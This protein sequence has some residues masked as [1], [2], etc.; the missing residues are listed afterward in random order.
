MFSKELEDLINY[1]LSDGEIDKK[2][3]QVIYK[4]AIE[5]GVDIDELEIYLKSKIYGQT[6]KDSKSI[7]KNN[8]TKEVKTKDYSNEKKKSSLKTIPLLEYLPAIISVF[9]S[10]IVFFYFDNL[11]VSIFLSFLTFMFSY[12]ILKFIFDGTKNLFHSFKYLMSFRWLKDVLN[13]SANLVSWAFESIFES[14][15]SIVTVLIGIGLLVGAIWL[16]W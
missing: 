9:L 15:F 5:E 16:F 7:P 1:S 10:I 2:E 13:G 8:N 11:F 3:K 12:T 14:I 6:K 4:K